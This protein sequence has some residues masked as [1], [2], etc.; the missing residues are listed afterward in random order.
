ML[1]R[2]RFVQAKTRGS[3]FTLFFG[4]ENVVVCVAH[5]KKEE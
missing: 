2:V 3:P 5:L 1:T 4:D